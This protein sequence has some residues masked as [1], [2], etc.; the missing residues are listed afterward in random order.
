[1]KNEQFDVNSIANS[2]P[3]ITMRP[4]TFFAFCVALI[5]FSTLVAVAVFFLNVRG[6]EEVMV[7]DVY[8]KDIIV[9]LMELQSKELDA[10]IQLRYSQ[11]ERGGII[12]Q[13]PA[14]GTIVK[15]GR[16]IRLVVSQGTMISNVGNY[17]GRKLDDVRSE[18]AALFGASETPLIF[19]KTPVL[20]QYSSKPVGTILEQ[21]PLPGTGISS[22]TELN[23]V[24]SRGEEALSVE[25]PNLN[26]M[27]LEAAL[28]VISK[29]G[30]RWRF[31]T[32]PAGT[33]EKAM[34]VA[35]QSPAAG[36][37]ISENRIAEITITE[38]QKNELQE[39]EVYGVFS[40]TLS[41]NPY[42]MQTSLE[43]ILPDGE[44]KTLV[45][46]GHYGGE[47]NCPY[48]LPK[49]SVL[50]LFLLKREVYREKI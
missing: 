37:Q 7:P 8:G 6:A 30:I 24:V 25:M 36:E 27:P 32:K 5:L 21:D 3:A 26:G 15:A 1:M 45:N 13:D 50:V 28:E 20:Y 16:K 19:I 29:S 47:F 42:P 11:L 10:R 44:R 35:A 14:P 43:A 4:V 34:T 22:Q 31:N 18:L 12:E 48:I 38:A 33:N 41:E 9:S 40:Y 2:K 46:A 39:G 23:L 17:V 49:G